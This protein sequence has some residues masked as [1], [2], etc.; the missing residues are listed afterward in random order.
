[1]ADGDAGRYGEGL[2][3]A[4]YEIVSDDGQH[5][6]AMCRRPYGHPAAEVD[7]IGHSQHALPV[8]EA[9]QDGEDR[10]LTAKVT[11]PYARY[12]SLA[13]EPAY[14]RL[15]EQITVQAGGAGNLDD[16]SGVE[17]TITVKAWKKP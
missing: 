15:I 8:V 1:M 7:G 10:T 4:Y 12:P 11:L 14:W 2:C 13:L 3:G 6:G 5:T 16:A 17:V 9:R